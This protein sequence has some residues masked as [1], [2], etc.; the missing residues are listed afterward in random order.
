MVLFASHLST[1]HGQLIVIVSAIKSITRGLFTLWAR[2]QYLL[3]LSYNLKATL[4]PYLSFSI[5]KKKM[6]ADLSPFALFLVN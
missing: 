5:S 6:N 1:S 4:D 2:G 3:T